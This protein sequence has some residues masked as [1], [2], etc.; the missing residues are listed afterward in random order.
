MMQEMIVRELRQVWDE[1]VRGF[2]HLLPRL[3]VI[4]IIAVVGWLVAYLLKV[5]VRNF[6][7]L[8]KFDRLSERAG[9]AQLLDTA[10]LPSATALLSQLVFWLAWL[11]FVLVGINALGTAGVQEHIATFLRFLPRFLVALAILFFGILAAN[12]FSRA[13]LLAAVNSNS[14]SPQVLSDATRFVIIVL[15]ISMAFE[16]LGLA[17]KTILIAFSIVFG[18]L[19][20]GLAIAFGLGG[21]DLA[22]RFLEKR[23]SDKTVRKAK[24][25]ELSPL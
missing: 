8:V 24:E 18:A 3:L 4:L 23:F 11:V 2:A 20:L 16:E 19:M 1:F 5:L 12:F 17:Q 25:D 6:L 14:P 9:A 15:A 7:R 13:A 21:R 22:R 10:A